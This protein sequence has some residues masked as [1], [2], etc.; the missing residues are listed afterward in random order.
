MEVQYAS[1]AA[2]G[3]T[4]V[5]AEVT[6]PSNA[7]ATA[8]AV[9]RQVNGQYNK[10]A[11]V[12][13]VV[14]YLS[15]TLN[16]GDWMGGWTSTV[17]VH[18]FQLDANNKVINEKL[19]S[20]PDDTDFVA[21]LSD[22]TIV[23]L[24]LTNASLHSLK[25]NDDNTWSQGPGL[26]LENPMQNSLPQS[27]YWIDDN[28][29]IYVNQSYW[30]YIY[31]R[32]SDGSWK[33]T[34]GFAF[35]VETIN[36]GVDNPFNVY[37]DGADTVIFAFPDTIYS[38]ASYAGYLVFYIKVNSDWEWHVITMDDVGFIGTD[39]QLGKL[40]FAAINS[41]NLVFGAPFEGLVAAPPPGTTKVL[42]LIDPLARPY[43]SNSKIARGSPSRR[44]LLLILVSLLRAL[45][46]RTLTS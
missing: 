24:S 43:W 19:I 44:F 45:V 36:N 29:I 31:A 13:Q 39:A 8:W 5:S 15:Q 28:H 18:L 46:S 20:V 33:V 34:D 23:Y 14:R 32:Q 11:S 35:D 26:E 1:I 2:H 41:K 16:N 37:F 12:P 9:F 10:I 25:F 3:D 21:L 17:G 40:S 6:D 4:I 27:P 38:G 22:N 42:L 7:T 30:T